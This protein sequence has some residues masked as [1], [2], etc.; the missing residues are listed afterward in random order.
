MQIEMWALA[1]SLIEQLAGHVDADTLARLNAITRLYA[2]G[3]ITP[4]IADRAM[5]RLVKR[6]PLV[7]KEYSVR[8]VEVDRLLAATDTKSEVKEE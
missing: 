8:R 6:I 5:K 3:Y 7:A 4:T 2:R 1:P